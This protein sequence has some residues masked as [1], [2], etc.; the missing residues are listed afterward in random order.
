MWVR[1]KRQLRA[2][3]RYLASITGKVGV[4]SAEKRE[5]EEGR[6]LVGGKIKKLVLEL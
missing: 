5:V 6:G 4:S 1:E 2:S 3:P